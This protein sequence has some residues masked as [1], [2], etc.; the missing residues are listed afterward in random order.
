M[1]SRKVHDNI[2]AERE[3]L[4][5]AQVLIELVIVAQLA[6]QNGDKH[7]SVKGV[8]ELTRDMIKDSI[9]RL[10]VVIDKM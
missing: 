5:T 1:K 6:E 2:H 7:V 3:C 10:G 4:A 9:E 8:L